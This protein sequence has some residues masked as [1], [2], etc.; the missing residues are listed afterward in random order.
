MVMQLRQTSV[1]K[2]NNNSFQPS[3][4]LLRQAP[5]CED[6]AWSQVALREHVDQRNVQVPIL[7]RGGRRNVAERPVQD[8]S[9]KKGCHRL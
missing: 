9:Q 3:A 7:Q 4:V 1:R 6:D 8:A 5:E 2:E